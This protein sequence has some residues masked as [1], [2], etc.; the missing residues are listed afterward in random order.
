MS[1]ELIVPVKS[2]PEPLLSKN[3]FGYVIKRTL[4]E[5]NYFKKKH[6]PGSNLSEWLFV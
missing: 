1:I 6:S 4:S 3:M 2:V 5:K